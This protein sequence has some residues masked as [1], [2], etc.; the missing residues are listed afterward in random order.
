[1]AEWLELSGEPGDLL[2]L[3]GKDSLEGQGRVS[4][5]A[6][7]VVMPQRSLH[8]CRGSKLAWSAGVADEGWGKSNSL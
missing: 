3:K 7:S 1:M 6:R 8:S 2:G 5:V 4:E